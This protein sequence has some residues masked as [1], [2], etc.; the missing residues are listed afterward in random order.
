MIGTSSR[1]FA[2]AAL[3]ALAAASFARMPQPSRAER[4]EQF[5]PRPEVAR[6]SAL[7]FRAVL[8]DYYWLQAVQVVGG[9]KRPSEH[10]ER[11][12]KLVDVV[13]TLDPWVSHPYRFAAIW[14]TEDRESVREAN[15]LLRRGIAHHP[16]DWRNHFYLGFNQFYYLDDFEG[17]A[18]T[19]EATVDLPGAPSYLHRLV[20][21]LRVR[22]HG[23]ETAAAFLAELARTTPDPYARAEYQKALDEIETERR[24]RALD[25]ARAA[26]RRRHGRDIERVE[27]L[28]R[29]PR[30]VLRRLPREIHG[31]EWV[32]DEESGRIV[33]SWYGHRYEPQFHPL[34][35]ERRR[36]FREGARSAGEGAL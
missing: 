21:R 14:L 7:G 5:I 11:I 17:A 33:S 3:A 13:T 34:D 12:G 23:L 8:A 1:I 10:S 16:R 28:V 24:A 2:A 31:W 35:R 4:G 9:A 30:P 19:L 6:A 32:I 15:R 26:Y 25:R 36:A 22:R 20:A 27:D 18:R 29:G